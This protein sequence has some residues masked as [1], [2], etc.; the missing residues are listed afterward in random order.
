MWFTPSSTARRTTLI[1]RSRSLGVPRSKAALP[2]RRIAP[3]PIRLTVR[4][5]SFQVPALAAL[6]ASEDTTEV[7]H[8][9]GR[10]ARTVR[11]YRKLAGAPL[12]H[13]L[14]V[15]FCLVAAL[16]RVCHPQGMGH[17]HGPHGP[18]DHHRHRPG[19]LSRAL[20]A[21]GHALRP[22]SH[23]A[24][25]KVDRALE[26]SADGVRAVKV[27]LLGLGVTCVLQ[28][29][30]VLWS[31]SVALLADTAHNFGDALTSVPLWIAFALNA[32]PATRRFT[33]G[34]GRAEELAGIFIVAMIAI[35]AL[36]SGAQSL[37]RLVAPE[38]V[39]HLWWVAAAGLIGFAGNEL[40]ALY[41]L[42][43]GRRIGSAAL[44][45]DGLH[46]RADGLT[47]LAVV[48][49]AAGVAAGFP[50]ADP[51]VGLVITAA[52]LV[53]LAGAARQV[54]RR[55]MDA[56]DPDLTAAAETAVR[57]T[58]GVQ[59]LDELRLRWIGHRLRAEVAITVDADLT[60]TRA[61]DIAEHARHNLLHAVP[62]LHDAIVH[63]SPS[64][65]GDHDPHRLVAHHFR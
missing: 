35:S 12:W 7:C 38:P 24:A 11:S 58:D 31:G 62:K 26:S 28:L 47:S 43:V 64:H 30:V 57:G 5:P 18:D 50:L 52:I 55:L 2:V 1:D 15:A 44:V 59:H 25:D 20:H 6:I 14:K 8:A 51:I 60:I 3:N 63:T 36:V 39:T 22:H 16:I 45:A 21:V 42:R 10:V 4:S 65:R 34:Y 9:A 32:R 56:V 13:L 27:G 53:V 19:G 33:Y 23:D 46:A 17:P 49:G 29:A 61:H 54:F 37:R 40:V 48:P 41:R